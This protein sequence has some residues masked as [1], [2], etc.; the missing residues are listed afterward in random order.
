MKPLNTK[1]QDL[2]KIRI[3]TWKERVRNQTQTNREEAEKRLRMAYGTSG[4]TKIENNEPQYGIDEPRKVYWVNS[5]KE[6]RELVSRMLYLS[7]NGFMDDIDF[8]KFNK[9]LENV[10][11]EQAD[12]FKSQA[13]QDMCFGFLDT[14]LFIYHDFCINDLKQED[15]KIYENVTEGV[16]HCGMFW[17]YSE[18]L[19]ITD[20]PEVINL[21]DQ[22]QFHGV[23][24]PAIRW[25]DGFKF[26]ALRNIVMPSYVVEWD[27]DDKRFV[28]M[29]AQED[30]LEVKREIL[31]K[32]GNEK[33]LKYFNA[34]LVDMRTVEQINRD[35]NRNWDESL[36]DMYKLYDV[37]VEG[38][39][40]KGLLMKNP[41]EI[42]VT[43]LEFV[44]KKCTSIEA[45]IAIRNG[46][47]GR[48][49]NVNGVTYLQQGDVP[50]FEEGQLED[51]NIKFQVYP[52]QLT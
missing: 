4:Y 36:G 23:D 44:T 49:D 17:S 52:E 24:G 9:A 29:Y 5:P 12:K 18:I 27:K 3:N 46:I 50:I 19:V 32:V 35:Y 15:K 6:G 2:L 38:R 21:N 45:A 42:G 41:S 40:C 43:H 48:I 28:E 30:N 11:E 16:K 33:F 22:D 37:T 20:A 14:A 25:E 7:E 39:E 13:I 51:E 34:K 8:D 26:Y 10:T 31:E 1:E 47:E